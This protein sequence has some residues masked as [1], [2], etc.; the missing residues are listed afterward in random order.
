MYFMYAYSTRSTTACSNKYVYTRMFVR[1]LCMYIKYTQ[2][3]HVKLEIKCPLQTRCTPVPDSPPP[4]KIRW[5]F[6]LCSTILGTCANRQGFSF[7][8]SACSLARRCACTR[9]PW[10][11]P[12][13]G[14]V[15]TTQTWLY[16]MVISE[17]CTR[18]LLSTRKASRSSSV[19]SAAN[20][21]KWLPIT[22]ISATCTVCKATT[23]TRYFATSVPEKPRNHESDIR[24]RLCGGG[25]VVH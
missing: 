22:I 25:Q 1:I 16:V 19:C 8:W 23:R 20:M 12:L 9:R 7:A 5:Y 14:T 2:D 18:R 17:T 15:T 21:R 24:L 4:R 13:H 6:L 3:I 10:I 11:L